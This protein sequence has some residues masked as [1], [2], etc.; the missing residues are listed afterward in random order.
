MYILCCGYPPFYSTQGKRLS[1]GMEKRIKRGQ[2]EFPEN[3]WGLISDQAKAIIDGMLETQP[4]RR[5]TIDKIIKIS[6]SVVVQI[7]HVLYRSQSQQE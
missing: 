5:L 7:D 4:E 1:P 2:Y 6:P 3:E